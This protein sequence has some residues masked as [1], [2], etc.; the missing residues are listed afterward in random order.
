VRWA[1]LGRAPDT[2]RSLIPYR[3]RW[4]FVGRAGGDLA[5]RPTVRSAVSYRAL[6]RSVGRVLPCALP[7]PTLRSAIFWGARS[8]PRR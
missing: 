3:A 4:R 6:W 1:V 2:V 7:L 5:D 8:P